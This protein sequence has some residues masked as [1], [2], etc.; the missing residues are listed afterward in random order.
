[1]KPTAYKWARPALPEDHAVSG[2]A[3]SIIVAVLGG[4]GVAF[5]PMVADSGERDLAAILALV[6]APLFGL[7]VFFAGVSLIMRE[8]R[9]YAFEQAIRA[10]EAE[11]V[12]K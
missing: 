9:R 7:G 5:G 1:M 10:G 2:L 8:I 6:S 4:A 11:P 12:G 3:F